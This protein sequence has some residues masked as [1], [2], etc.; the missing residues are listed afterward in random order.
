MVIADGRVS[1]G[2]GRAFGDRRACGQAV[3]LDA[4]ATSEALF[5]DEQFANMLLVGAACQGRRAAGEC[6]VDRAGDQL[7]GVA[8]NTNVQAFRRGRQSVADQDTL[9]AVLGS[10]NLHAGSGILRCGAGGTRGRYHRSGGNRGDCPS[11]RRTGGYADRA[12][13][14]SIWIWLPAWMTPEWDR[15]LDAV[16]LSYKLMAYRTVRVA[17]L[18]ADPVFAETVA[19]TYGHDAST[20]VRLVHR[21]SGKVG[22][23]H[24]VGWALGASGAVRTADEA[25]ARPHWIPFGHTDVRH[26]TG[27]DRQVPRSDRAGAVRPAVGSRIDAGDKAAVTGVAVAARHGARLRAHQN[28]VTWPTCGHASPF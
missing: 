9:A 21:P 3:Y 7:N 26:R 22:V 24:K 2:H 12:Y 27:T 25:A 28:S 10:R 23:D 5:G 18:T 14:R 17:R 19:R 4:V 1:G 20:A 11:L 16:A 8:V 15:G 13:A 6:G